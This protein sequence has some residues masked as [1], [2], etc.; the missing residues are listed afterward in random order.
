MEEGMANIEFRV[1]LEMLAQLVDS[2]SKTI[3]EAVQII[4]QF[5]PE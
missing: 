4:R 2:K 3:G 5:K 1:L